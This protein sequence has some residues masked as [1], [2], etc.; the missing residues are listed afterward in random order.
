LARVRFLGAVSFGLVRSPFGGCCSFRALQI[1][2]WAFLAASFVFNV[3][4]SGIFIFLYVAETDLHA[5]I[6]A[7]ILEDI[8]KRFIIYQL[9]KAIKYMH[10]GQVIH[11]DMK[12]WLICHNIII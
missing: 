7:N 12:V 8:H 5:V 9:L 4:V 2:R 1:P 6:R 10:S 11:R 3:H